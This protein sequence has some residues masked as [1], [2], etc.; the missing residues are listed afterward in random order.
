MGDRNPPTSAEIIE[1]RAL[2]LLQYSSSSVQSE[3]EHAQGWLRG[4]STSSQAP[5]WQVDAIAGTLGSLSNAWGRLTLWARS[6]STYDRVRDDLDGSMDQL[7]ALHRRL[8]QAGQTEGDIEVLHGI[9][10]RL[11][12]VQTLVTSGNQSPT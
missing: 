9:L 2:E 12:Q 10:R 4:A 11:R 6:N 7:V 1:N 5:G 3:L 8:V